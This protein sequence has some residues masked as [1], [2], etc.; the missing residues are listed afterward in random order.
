MLL[1]N[2][3]RVMYRYFNAELVPASYRHC[4]RRRLNEIIT[5][6]STDNYFRYK[7]TGGFYVY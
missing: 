6:D 5:R 1:I 3:L 4:D 7:V 2:L